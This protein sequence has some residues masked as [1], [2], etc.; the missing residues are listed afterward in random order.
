[1]RPVSLKEATAAVDARV[2]PFSFLGNE[3]A[4]PVR[5]HLEGLT[6]TG[7]AVAAP[8]GGWPGWRWAGGGWPGAGGGGGPARARDAARVR[9]ARSGARLR[10]PSGRPAPSGGRGGA[11]R[12]LSLEEARQEAAVDRP[13]EDD[14]GQ[15]Q[16]RPPVPRAPSGG[17]AGVPDAAP[18]PGGARA[19]R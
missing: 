1:G 6:R 17:P 10:A 7:Q 2:G 4:G 13:V 18:A 9:G 3:L 11:A 16:G 15:P 19:P 14:G 12:S 8:A 5:A